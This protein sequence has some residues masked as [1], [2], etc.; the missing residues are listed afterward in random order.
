MEE[1]KDAK[2]G[3]SHEVS[4][5]VP[6]LH[7]ILRQF[8]EQTYVVTGKITGDT[9]NTYP[10]IDLRSAF[11]IEG[12]GK[13]DDGPSETPGLKPFV[14]VCQLSEEAARACKIEVKSGDEVMVKGR[15]TSMDSVELAVGEISVV[16]KARPPKEGNHIRT[17]Q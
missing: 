9:L 12:M 11:H 15:L 6:K 4:A 13:D 17:S 3:G 1:T 2:N 14:A 10:L 16:E 7:R 8:Q 5:T